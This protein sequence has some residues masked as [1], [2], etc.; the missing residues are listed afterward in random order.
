M[1]T[2]RNTRD[3]LNRFGYFGKILSFVINMGVVNKKSFGIEHSL[4]C[5]GIGKPDGVILSS[6]AKR[7][8]HTRSRTASSGDCLL[9]QMSAT[10]IV[11]KMHGHLGCAQTAK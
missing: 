7:S 6:E 1:Y 9:P 2:G 5:S 4:V 8:R 3:D 10:H 11:S